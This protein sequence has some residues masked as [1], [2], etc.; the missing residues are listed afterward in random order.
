MKQTEYQP[1][2]KMYGVSRYMRDL[3][4]GVVGGKHDGRKVMIS[5]RGNDNR[6]IRLYNNGFHAVLTKDKTYRRVSAQPPPEMRPGK[7]DT[8]RRILT[9]SH[10]RP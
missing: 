5:G 10:Q 7:D 1:L 8:F 9:P 2:K 4:G 3:A 6:K